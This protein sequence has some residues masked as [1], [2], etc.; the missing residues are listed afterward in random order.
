MVLA[1]NRPPGTRPL[2]IASGEEDDIVAAGAHLLDIAGRFHRL[3]SKQL[4]P[5]AAILQIR[6]TAGPP[7]RFEALDALELHA[8]GGQ[9]CSRA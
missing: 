9:Q 6:K 1:Q 7:F 5:R 8:G 3:F 4:A 2:A